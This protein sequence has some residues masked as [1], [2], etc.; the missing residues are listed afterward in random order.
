MK[1][2]VIQRCGSFN[3]IQNGGGW[4]IMPN[5]LL[6]PTPPPYSRIYLNLC[7][8]GIFGIKYLLIF[9]NFQIFELQQQ[10]EIAK[11]YHSWY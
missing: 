3:P 5:K 8:S 6:P 11:E 9:S 10:R 1:F 2:N 4:Q 7:A